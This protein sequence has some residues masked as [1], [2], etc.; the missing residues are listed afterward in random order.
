M[1]RTY[2]ML[3]LEF[4][5]LD[6][7]HS[8][9][10]DWGIVVFDKDTF[11]PIQELGERCP[12]LESHWNKSWRDHKGRTTL[13]FLQENYP[14]E[15]FAQTVIYPSPHFNMDEYREMRQEYFFRMHKAITD[16]I[17]YY[18]QKELVFIINHP[19]CD[20][21]LLKRTY[22]KYGVEYPVHYQ[23]HK[24]MDSLMMAATGI[25]YDEHYKDWDEIK[26]P[27]AHTAIAD[28]LE[29]IKKLKFFWVTLP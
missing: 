26:T 1:K 28:C 10:T 8:H 23:N 25:L 4:T 15:L 17:T 29:Q 3:D 14:P 9:I 12:V 21:T 2:A 11:E 24:D 13:Q 7:N 20:A 6:L 18:G 16:L 22:K 19:E 27:T 5:S